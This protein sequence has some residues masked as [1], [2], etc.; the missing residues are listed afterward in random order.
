[1]FVQSLVDGDNEWLEIACE[2]GKDI[3]NNIVNNV[4]NGRSASSNKNNEVQ[5]GEAI[6]ISASIVDFL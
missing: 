6:M 5:S 2:H 3:A 1:M 4:M